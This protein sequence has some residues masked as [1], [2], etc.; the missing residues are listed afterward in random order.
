[1]F[2]TVLQVTSILAV[3]QHT[4]SYGF[5]TLHKTKKDDAQSTVF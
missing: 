1:M 2:L 5:V 4:K 3:V